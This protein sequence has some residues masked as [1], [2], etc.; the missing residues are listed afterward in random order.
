MTGGG[1]NIPLC[2]RS[3]KPS[4]RACQREIEMSPSERETETAC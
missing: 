2:V 4:Y 1:S 3:V